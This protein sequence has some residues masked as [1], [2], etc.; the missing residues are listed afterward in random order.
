MQQ[1]SKIAQKGQQQ[2]SA[3][4]RLGYGTTSSMLGGAS[5]LTEQAP[6]SRTL[7]GS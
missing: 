5:N 4:S 6:T 3:V 2:A 1:V 7:L